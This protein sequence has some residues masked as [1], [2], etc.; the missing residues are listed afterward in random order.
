MTVPGGVTL[1][2]P[3]RSLLSAGLGVSFSSLASYARGRSRIPAEVLYTHLEPLRAGGSAAVP[4]MV[5]ER[6]EL[7]IYTGFPRR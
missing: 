4:A 2:T 5:T 6:L 1:D 7:R 3:S